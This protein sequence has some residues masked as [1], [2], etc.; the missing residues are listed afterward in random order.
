M[1][2]HE[3]IAAPEVLKEFVEKAGDKLVVVDTRNLDA[4]K[5]PEDQKSFAVAGLP[6]QDKRRKAIHLPFDRDNK[7]MPLPPDDLPKDT[8]IITHCHAGKRGQMAKEFLE[9]HGFTNVLNGGG[10]SHTECWAEFGDK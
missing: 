10:P 3:S 1:P 8:P 9:A 6:S 2:R 7:V 4:G 5:E